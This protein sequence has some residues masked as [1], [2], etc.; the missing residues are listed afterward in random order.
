MNQGPSE[1]TS[2]AAEP[3]I[4]S[5]GLRT[6]VSFLLFV[7]LFAVAVAIASSNYRASGL[8]RQLRLRF[9][10]PYLQTL[11]MDMAYNFHLTHADELDVDHFFEMEIESDGGDK[12]TVTL[13]E[14]GIRPAERR[15]RYQQLAFETAALVGN[16][17]GESVLPRAVA[18]RLLV[19]NG[20]TRGTIRCRA[21]HLQEPQDVTSSDATRSDPFSSRYYR[22][23][24][25]AKAFNV[26]GQVQVLKS[27]ASAESA[28]AAV[29]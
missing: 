12:K 3:A 25:E 9:L 22:T 20:G 14:A 8:V 21:H 19:E 18:A 23:A 16:D 17:V 7:H 29:P 11:N 24:Y 26:G 15:R 13:P 5:Q 4:A 2:D 27:E 28:P 1:T 10:T 6:L